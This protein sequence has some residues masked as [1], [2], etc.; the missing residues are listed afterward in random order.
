MYGEVDVLMSPRLENTVPNDAVYAPI[1]LSLRR[2]AFNQDVAD[3]VG[4][5]FDKPID[6]HLLVPKCKFVFYKHEPNK[7]FLFRV[8]DVCST[9]LAL[10]IHI[11]KYLILILATTRFA[12]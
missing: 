4:A 8:E 3:K 12:S 6:R 1:L 7:T 9:E 5:Q 11:S 10:P 2:N